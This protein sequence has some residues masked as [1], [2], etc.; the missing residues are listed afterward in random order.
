MKMT[1][2]PCC[3]K[4]VPDE[5]IELRRQNTRY[6][7][8]SKNYKESCLECFKADCDY[9]DEKWKEVWGL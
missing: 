8:E 5:D 6:A 3:N 1:I 7:D 9:W 2:C 4:L